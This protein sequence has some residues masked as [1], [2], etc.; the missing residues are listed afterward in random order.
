MAIIFCNFASA[1]VLDAEITNFYF[2]GRME[3]KDKIAISSSDLIALSKEF[4]DRDVRNAQLQMLYEMKEK[5]NLKLL[6]E[7]EQWKKKYEEEKKRADY[8]QDLVVQFKRDIEGLKGVIT[9]MTEENEKKTKQELA[10][11]LNKLMDKFLILSMLQVE[12][13]MRDKV[14]DLTIASLLKEFVIASIPEQM[15]PSMI[16]IINSKMTLPDR[17]KP[18]VP[19]EQNNENCQIFNGQIQNSE[20]NGVK[21]DE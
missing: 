1:S 19:V 2:F 5:E 20:F 12:G 21:K 10:D 11:M 14:H 4:S 13:F 16:A 7:A 6:Q 9:R 17:P 15:L 3:E 18:V 8:N